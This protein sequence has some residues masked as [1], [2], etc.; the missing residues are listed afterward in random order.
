MTEATV[1]FSTQGAVY[2]FKLHA[3]TTTQGLIVKFAVVPQTRLT[4]PSLE[5]SLTNLNAT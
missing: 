1:G 3:L 5:R 4:S 2:G